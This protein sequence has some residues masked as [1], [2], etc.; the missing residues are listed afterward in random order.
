METAFSGG[1]GPT[2]VSSRSPSTAG[3]VGLIVIGNELRGPTTVSSASI[4]PASR[5][6]AARLISAVDGRIVVADGDGRKD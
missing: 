1:G 6:M 4:M 2:L 3:R 5:R